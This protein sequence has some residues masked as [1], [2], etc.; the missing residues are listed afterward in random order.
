MGQTRIRSAQGRNKRPSA[1]QAGVV[2]YGGGAAYG[3]RRGAA[4][5]DACAPDSH[6]RMKERGTHPRS[7]S[8]AASDMQ[9]N[10]GLALL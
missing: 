4:R 7:E 3:E 10:N 5:S 8:V 6:E 2:L 1:N 9:S